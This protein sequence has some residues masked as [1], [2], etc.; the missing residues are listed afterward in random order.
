VT[1]ASVPRKAPAQNQAAPSATP[2]DALEAADVASTPRPQRDPFAGMWKIAEA[3]TTEGVPYEGTL[4]ITNAGPRYKV[5]WNLAG[6]T[7]NGL[8]LPVGNRLCVAYNGEDFSV[9]VYKIAADGSM[10]GRWAY[11]SASASDRDGLENVAAGD[12]GELEGIRAVK[13]LNP[14]ATSY[15]GTIEISETGE[16]YQLQW[17]ILGRTIKGVGIKVDDNLFVASAYEGS[18]GV[19]SYTFEGS[20]AKGVW[21]LGGE[22]KLG[23]EDLAK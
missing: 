18:F 11:S 19:V 4:E 15:E 7:V 5:K 21:T 2:A 10:K 22:S 17:E 6:T 20:R 8:A 14:D 16:T 13:G 9:I 23:T 3:T 1:S 12:A